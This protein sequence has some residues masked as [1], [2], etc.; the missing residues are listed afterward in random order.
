M[1][2]AKFADILNLR[3]TI[4]RFYD[5]YNKTHQTPAFFPPD[6]P[7]RPRPETFPTLPARPDRFIVPDKGNRVAW[8]FLAG[9]FIKAFGVIDARVLTAHL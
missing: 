9:R 8:K 6:Y 7:A 3:P 2:A 4:K 5:T 1:P